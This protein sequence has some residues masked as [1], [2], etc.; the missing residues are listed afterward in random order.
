MVEEF[1]T[2]QFKITRALVVALSEGSSK[3]SMVDSNF[4]IC[5]PFYL[6]ATCA[7]V[8][9]HLERDLLPN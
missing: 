4:L 9:L 6:N 3:Q 1:F 7:R 2:V 8:G 5:H